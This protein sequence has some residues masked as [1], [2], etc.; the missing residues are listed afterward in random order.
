[1]ASE[2]SPARISIYDAAA[3]NR[4]RTVLPVV[5]FTTIMALLG[6]FVG[7]YIYPGGGLAVLPF[8]LALSLGSAFT[9]YFAGD[10]IVLAQIP[11]R[12]LAPNEE[13]E[14]HNFLETLE[15]GLG[16]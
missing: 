12:E 2:T 3:A 7:E 8:A 10:R 1:M 4:W 11:A 13:T 5:A 6:Y 16:I 9:S 15:L 14:P